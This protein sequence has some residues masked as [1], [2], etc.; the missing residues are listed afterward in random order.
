MKIRETILD[1]TQNDTN[2][3]IENQISGNSWITSIDDRN[4]SY[5]SNDVNSNLNIFTESEKLETQSK[6]INGKDS[7]FDLHDL[8]NLNINHLSSKID[9]LRE[10]CSKSPIDILCIDETTLDSSYPDVQFEIPGYQYPLYR[11][12]RNKNG[13]NKIVFIR[14]GLINKRLKAFGGD[15]SE[16]ICLEV[17]VSKKVLFISYVYRPPYNDNKD[18]FISELSNILSLATRKYENILIIGDLNIDISN[19]KKDNGNYLSNSCDTFSLKNLITDITCA[20]STNGTS[21][22]VLLTNKSRCF[23]HKATFETDV[24]DCHILILSFFK[25]YFRKLPSK[26]IEYR[27]YKNKFLYK[28]DQELSK[29]SI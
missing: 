23:H 8:A 27:N 29:G 2:K 14:E 7:N 21:I 3:L 22:D 26:Y 25:A 28:L 6:H 1:L 13:G 24:S 10:I 5:D 4:I 16:T 18:I 17:T 15:I 11:E 12:D 20:K 9:Y 19:M